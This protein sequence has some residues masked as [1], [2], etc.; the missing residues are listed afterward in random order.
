MIYLFVLTFSCSGHHLSVDRLAS[1]LPQHPKQVLNRGPASVVASSTCG[2]MAAPGR[3]KDKGRVIK[4][5]DPLVWRIV[6]CPTRRESALACWR[7]AVHPLWAEAVD[8]TLATY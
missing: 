2:W 4:A 3:V 7:A 8:A 1:N 5:I 6:W